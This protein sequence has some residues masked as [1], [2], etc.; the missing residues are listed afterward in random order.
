M[1]TKDVLA[2]ALEALEANHKHHQ[3][4]DDYGGYPESELCAK[5]EQAITAIKQAQEQKVKLIPTAEEMGTPTQPQAITPETGNAATPEASAI[6][7]GNGQAQEPVGFGKILGTYGKV[8]EW[9]ELP[10]PAPKQAEPVESE[11]KRGFSDGMNEAPTGDCWVRA[12]DEAMVG[13]HLGVADMTDDYGTAKKKL[14]DL[15][16]WHVEVA[17]ESAPKQAEPA[18]Y[19]LVPEQVEAAWRAGWAACR[20]AEFV[21]EEAEDEAWGMSETCAN[22][23]WESAAPKQPKP[24]WQPIA[25]A[26]KDGREI[27]LRNGD[28]VGAATWIKWPS[29]EHEEAGEG[30]TICHDGDSWDEEKSPTHWQPLPTARKQPTNKVQE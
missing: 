21:G 6:T 20:D 9:P 16:C 30:W 18:G 28:R 12:V 23:D 4:Y 22:A 10:E 2:L 7:A 15:I 26:P 8:V 17:Q 1:T 3:E 24:S 27:I 25:S 11:Y 29:S 19:K 13:A 14:N 5:N